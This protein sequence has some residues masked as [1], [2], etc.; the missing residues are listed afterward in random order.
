VPGMALVFFGTF[1]RTDRAWILGQLRRF[2]TGPS[3]T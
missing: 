1:P 3:V 2:R